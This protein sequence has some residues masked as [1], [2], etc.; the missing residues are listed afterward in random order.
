MGALPHRDVATP[1]GKVVAK[2]KT[3]GRLR[4][5]AKHIYGVWI[6]LGVSV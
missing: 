1:E 3:K 5:V 2:R 6:T 4:W